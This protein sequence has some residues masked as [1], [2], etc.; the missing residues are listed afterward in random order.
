LLRSDA[1]ECREQD[2]VCREAIIR[3]VA[4]RERRAKE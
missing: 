1:P 3:Q 2:P 4:E